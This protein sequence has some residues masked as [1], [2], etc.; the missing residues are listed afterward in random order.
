MKAIT[1]A[2]LRLPSAIPRDRPARPSSVRH[3]QLEHQAEREDK[4][5]DQA[6][7]LV[8]LGSMLN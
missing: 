7:I 8:D 3:G 2:H 5:H 6:E 4:V 1:I